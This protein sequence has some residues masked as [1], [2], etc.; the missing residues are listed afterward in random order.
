MIDIKDYVDVVSK[1][2][3]LIYRK[4]KDSIRTAAKLMA[5][6]YEQGKL[7]H[8]FG[9]VLILQWLEKSSF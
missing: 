3:E 8:I 2:P 9:T 7:I 6:I 5:D 4:E 1:L